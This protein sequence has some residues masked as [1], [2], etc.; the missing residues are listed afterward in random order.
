MIT[1]VILE[2][3]CMIAL[4][5]NDISST[6]NSTTLYA[7]RSPAPIIPPSYTL[8]P[9]PTNLQPSSGP[10]RYRE[11]ESATDLITVGTHVHGWHY[12]ISA[13]LFVWVY[14]RRRILCV[15]RRR[16]LQKY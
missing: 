2:D 8:D 12:Q 3:R 11:W 4:R 13:V 9:Y 10:P 7:Y 5:S 15:P 6:T 16:G 1:E 14:V